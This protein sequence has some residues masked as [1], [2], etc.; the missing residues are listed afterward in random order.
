MFVK[1]HFCRVFLPGLRPGKKCRR[2]LRGLA[3]IFLKGRT[4]RPWAKPR[5]GEA[6][7]SAAHA[8]GIEAEILLAKPKDWSG[9]PGSRLRRER[10]QIPE[11]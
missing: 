11:S 6:E 1:G 2:K 4:S 10:A 7:R 5:V 3:A 9:K 8:R